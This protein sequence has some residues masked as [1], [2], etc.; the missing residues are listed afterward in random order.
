MQAPP[1][2]WCLA[3]VAVRKNRSN[4]AF[5]LS[6][7]LPPATPEYPLARSTLT[8]ILHPH[9]VNMGKVPQ[10]QRQGTRYEPYKNSSRRRASPPPD[11]WGI[12]A[13]S[14][15]AQL[16]GGI[17]DLLEDISTRFGSRDLRELFRDHANQPGPL[18]QAIETWIQYDEVIIFLTSYFVWAARTAVLLANRYFRFGGLASQNSPTSS[19]FNAMVKAIGTTCQ[20]SFRGTRVERLGPQL[21][22][23]PHA[24]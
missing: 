15:D 20:D 16:N 7:F 21:V 13:G 17:F 11:S 5:C 23:Q 6:T 19:R 9:T 1:F 12:H 8:H 10:M 14:Q 24:T 3:V 2:I 18:G 4:K 22:N